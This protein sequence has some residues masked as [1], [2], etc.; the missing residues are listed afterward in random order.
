MKK[1]L[2]A[3]LF[4]IT[5]ISYG[6]VFDGW[7][8][9]PE[10]APSNPTKGR[11]YVS[12]VDDAVWYYNGTIWIDLTASSTGGTSDHGAL[13]GL[14]DDDHTQY[15]DDT[16]AAAWLAALYAD[17]DTVS[18]N[19]IVTTGNQTKTGDLSVNN[20]YSNGNGVGNLGAAGQGSFDFAYLNTLKTQQIEHLITNRAVEFTQALRVVPYDKSLI[21]APLKGTL[22]ADT[23][24]DD[25]LYYNGSSWFNITS[26]SGGGTDDQTATEVNYD[27]TASGLTATNTQAALDEVAA[28]SSNVEVVTKAT[29]QANPSNYSGVTVLTEDA[30]TPIA[31]PT[32][33]QVLTADGA[34]NYSWKTNNTQLI[35]L[36][37]FNTRKDNNTLE[38]GVFYV[39]YKITTS[40]VYVDP[41]QY[42]SSGSTYPEGTRTL[43]A[44][45]VTE[46]LITSD[47]VSG[48]QLYIKGIDGSYSKTITREGT[49]I[50]DILTS[51]QTGFVRLDNDDALKI[52]NLD[53]P[54]S[55]SH[56]IGM[57]VRIDPAELASYSGELELLTS[58]DDNYKI[59]LV[60]DGGAF[61]ERRK[62]SVRRGGRTANVASEFVEQVPNENGWGGS[63]PSVGLYE[64][65]GLQAAEWVWIITTGKSSS[66]ET[67][68]YRTFTYNGGSTNF[69]NNNSQAIMAAVHG[70]NP[71]G[72]LFQRKSSNPSY[73]EGD[74]GDGIHPINLT[75]IDFT[76]SGSSNATSK[77]ID[78]ARIF[79]LEEAIKLN[80]Q[81][82]ITAGAHPAQLRPLTANE[83]CYDF[84][85]LPTGVTVLSGTPV[86]NPDETS[87]IAMTYEGNNT[88]QQVLTFAN[89][90]VQ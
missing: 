60:G 25:L 64:T 31:A 56:T 13:T 17:L 21:T 47:D 48:G 44:D 7:Q 76:V 33:G 78:V 30:P 32:D 77:T 52:G 39:V 24:E 14:G 67:T 19:D 68:D 71:I 66:D 4:F 61:A 49:G 36:D 88:N 89:S 16:R 35:E 62:P 12:N 6:Q 81:A 45:A 58:S 41:I 11:F 79:Y 3:I 2:V 84:S 73:D 55:Q 53:R 86:F 51:S 65:T 27:N 37:V 50:S 74:T 23:T 1:L 26:P 5:S 70:F 72:Q 22:L 85:S 87:P 69:Q 83:F 90:R 75:S 59:R 28:S 80:E 9:N 8:S 54:V 20:L 29:E 63:T 38:D 43:I 57:L 40:G 18:A 34:G 82:L 10:G 42:N 15:H 46:T